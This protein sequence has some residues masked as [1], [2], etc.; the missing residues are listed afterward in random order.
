MGKERVVFV[1]A[2]R[3]SRIGRRPSIHPIA[4]TLADTGVRH[5]AEYPAASSLKLAH[6]AGSG[7]SAI[8]SVSARGDIASRFEYRN[9]DPVSIEAAMRDALAAAG[10]VAPRA[11]PTR[12]GT[13]AR[14]LPP[15]RT[16]GALPG[17][18]LPHSN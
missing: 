17:G 16:P 14:L 3:D 13:G 5:R 7:L 12:D 8:C 18:A 10:T 9:A 6:H 11:F 2:F 4:G 1:S 15:E